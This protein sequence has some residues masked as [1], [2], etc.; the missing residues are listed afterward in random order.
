MLEVP[1]SIRHARGRGHCCFGVR[2][3]FLFGGIG[4]GS[5][6]HGRRHDLLALPTQVDV[7][8]T[9]LPAVSLSERFCVNAVA[10]QSGVLGLQSRIL[11]LQ[12]VHGELLFRYLDLFPYCV[13]L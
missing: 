5:M 7:D 13:V 1:V 2:D 9:C 10:A 3:P 6:C 8:H 11:N 4:S 12:P